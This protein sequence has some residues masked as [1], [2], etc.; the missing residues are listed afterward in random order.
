VDLPSTPLSALSSPVPLWI[1][2]RGLCQSATENTA[3]AFDASVAAGFTALETDLRLTRDGR[4]ILGH[5]ADLVRVAG[6]ARRW[7]EV[8]AAELANVRLKGGE[9]P[10][11]F[12]EFA[13]RY[14]AC[15]WVLDLKLPDAPKAVEAL[16]VWA[17]GRDAWF[18]E[19]TTFLAWRPADEAA[20]LAAF[21]GARCYARETECYRAGLA[22]LVAGGV[23]AGL[24]VGRTYSLSPRLRGVPLF[25]RRYVERYHAAGARVLAFLPET[26]AD[27]DAA[28]EAG[29]DEILTN[30]RFAAFG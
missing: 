30:E 17:R 12:E 15:Q 8:D 22:V 3:A 25:R 7:C 23:G 26:E 16:A 2:H 9:P 18:V 21:P 19:K 1:S 13:A 24:V 10:L 6:D 28:V 20:V 27:A 29:F 4:L 11:L 14:A 5:D